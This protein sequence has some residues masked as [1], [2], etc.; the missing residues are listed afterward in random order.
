M[1][2]LAS[3]IAVDSRG[4]SSVYVVSDSR[5]SWPGGSTWD[6]ATKIFAARSR[7]II[8]GYCGDIEGPLLVLAQLVQAIDHGLLFPDESSTEQTAEVLEDYLRRALANYPGSKNGFSIVVAWR[9]GSEMKSAM[10]AAQID[11][12]GDGTIRRTII[13]PPS[14]SSLIAA[15]GSGAE[16]VRKWYAHWQ[17][18][19]EGRTSRSVF[20]AFCDALAG[21]EDSK[22]GGPVQLAAIYRTGGGRLIGVVG[23][24]GDAAVLGV[25]LWAGISATAVEWRNQAFER[26]TEGGQ[27]LPKAQKH[28]SPRGLGRRR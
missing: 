24:N 16:S 12:L 2:S 22:S 15:V 10:N 4:P 5:I 20:T 27:L 26:V 18:T 19:R 14:V 23:N 7:P 13:T 1:T 17:S 9:L 28:R 21:S 25:P 8:F 6:R 3:W 11:R